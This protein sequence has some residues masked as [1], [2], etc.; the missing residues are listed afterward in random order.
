VVKADAPFTTGRRSA[1]G[2]QGLPQRPQLLVRGA[3]APQA[4][5]APSCFACAARPV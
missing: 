3:L 1:Q 4:S 2:R 5:S